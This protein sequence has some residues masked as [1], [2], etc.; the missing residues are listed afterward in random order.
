M[1]YKKPRNACSG[2]SRPL[3]MKARETLDLRINP[4]HSGPL[5]TADLNSPFLS[6]LLTI[7]KALNL[8][9]EPLRPLKDLNLGPT[10]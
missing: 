9:S 10:D 1:G 2:P 6:T 5:L 3:P 4:E 7:K 8:C